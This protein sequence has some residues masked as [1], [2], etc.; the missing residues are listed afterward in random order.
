MKIEEV[1]SDPEE[2][3]YEL[4]AKLRNEVPWTKIPILIEEVKTKSPWLRR[5]NL[6]PRIK[7]YYI[8]TS[9]T[10]CNYYFFK[11]SLILK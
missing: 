3:I 11:Q 6:K 9:E 8:S 10:P 4:R 2:D 1:F 7:S 5:W